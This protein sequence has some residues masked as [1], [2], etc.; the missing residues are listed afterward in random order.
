[1]K[2]L[3]SPQIQ[4]VVDDAAAAAERAHVASCAACGARVAERRRHMDMLAGLVADVDVPRDTVTRVNAALAGAHV[5]GATRLRRDEPARWR[6]AAW[7]AAGLAAA[8]LAAVFVVTPML[9]EGRG[10]VSA[11]EILAHSASRLAQPIGGG[12]ELL[13][14]ELTIDGVPKE[15]AADHADG[16]YRVRQAI[17]HGTPGRFRFA[18]FAPDG[19][20][21]SAIAQDPV[22]HRRVVMVNPEGQPYRFEVNVPAAP[23][24]SLPE[25][26]RLHMEAS[27]SMMQA[28][29][30]QILQVVDTPEGRQYRIE[31]PR[32]NAPVSSPLWDLTEARVVI[33]ADD[34]RVVEFAV[35][36]TFLKQAYS[37]SYRL[38][39]RAVETTVA[40]DTFEVPA[41]PGEIVLTGEGT[42]IPA[43]DIMML[44]LRELA[45]NKQLKP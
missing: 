26:E 20:P 33:D 24:L 41:Q 4:A 9:K 45:K 22:A 19:T 37:V 23:G 2:C 13:E 10:A 40:A 27:I 36:G 5:S 6:P 7:G 17:D 8:T 18:S 30:N 42:A 31:V 35:K 14:Y 16:T 12:I 25:L 32:I 11:A 44:A 1:M 38:V 34:Y 3:S 43:H 29:G 39:S 21:V 28:S 15:M